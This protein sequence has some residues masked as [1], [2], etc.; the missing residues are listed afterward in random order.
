MNIYYYYYY[1]VI[2]N[3]NMNMASRSAEFDQIYKQMT[4]INS[5]IQ[6]IQK[7]VIYLIYIYIYL[8]LYILILIIINIK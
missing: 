5:Q 8:Y 3:E 7:N 1:L 6:N 2:N 4:L